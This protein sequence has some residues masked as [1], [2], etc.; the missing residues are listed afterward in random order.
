MDEFD[1][2]VA[3]GQANAEAIEL[4]RRHCRHARIELVHGNSTVGSSLN[5]S[6]GLMEVR[7]EH[8]PPPR[9]QSFQALELA[10]DFYQENCLGCEYRDG[11]GDLPNLA[12]V[13]AEF[14]TRRAAARAAAQ[15][16]ADQLALRREQRC[17]RRRQMR[18]GEGHV[19]RD[20][21]D[22]IDA[23]DRAGPRTAPLTAEEVRAERRVLDEV[24]GAPELFN[25]VLVDSLVEIAE[26]TADATALQALEALVRFG[27]CPPR[28]AL[29]AACTVL[30]RQRSVEAGQLLAFVEPELHP[31][32]LVNVLDQLINL[33]SVEEHVIRRLPSSPDG[34]IAASRV[35]LQAV[36]ARITDHLGSDDDRSREAGADAARELL[37]I[38]ATRIVTLGPPLVASVRGPDRV[39]AGNPHPAS[40][41]A[42]ALAEGWRG[43]PELTR[44]IVE[45]H[46]SRANQEVKDELSRVPR[47]LQRFREPW[48]AS[49]RATS[50]AISFAVRRAGGDWGDEAADRSADHLEGL[51][52]EIPDAVAI[53]IDE[54]LATILG[55]CSPVVHISA[56]L[57]E[58]A[59]PSTIVALER[60][61]RRI[62]RTTRRR[63]LAAAVGRTAAVSPVAVLTSV[64]ALFSAT[65]GDEGH[66]RAVRTTMLDVLEDAVAP[67][68]LRDILPITFT[69]LLDADQVVRSAGIDLWVAC[70]RVADSL[71]TELTELASPLLEDSHVVV[72]RKMLTQIPQLHLPAESAP[73]LILLVHAWLGTYAEAQSPEPRVVASAIRALRSLARQLDDESQI[74]AWHG[75]ALSYVD[76]CDPYDRERLLTSWWPVELRH[77]EA[78]VKMALATAASPELVDYYNQRREPLLQ[79]LMDRPQLLAGIALVDI[80]P[81]S[82]VHGTSHPWR[83]LEPVELLQAAGRWADALKIAG[84]VETRQPPGDEG[85]PG[86]RLAGTIAGAAKL[87][88]RLVEGP[89]AADALVTLTDAVLAAV[90]GVEASVANGVKEGQLRSTLDGA[91]ASATAARV[92]LAPAVPEPTMA[93]D[94]LEGAVALLQ[95]VS[96]VHAS[97]TQ[98]GWIARAW[99]IAVLLFRF[100][101]AVRAVLGEAPALLQAAQRQAQVLGSE[102]TEAGGTVIPD[103]LVE[104]LA[105]VENVAEPGAAQVAWQRLG[106]TPV[107]LSLVGT[108]LLPR[109][110]GFDHPSTEREEPPRA[111]CVA[112][113]RGVPVTDILVLRRGELY[114][115]GMTVR[116][117]AVPEW[118]ETCIVEPVTT[119][120]RDALALPR[121]EFS[122]GDGDIDEHGITLTGEE[123]LHCA[124]DQPILGPA[125]DCPLQVRLLG[126]GQDQMI[127]VVGLQRLRLRPFDPSCDALT[128][129]EQT[130]N[131]L[132]TMFG[133]LDSPDFDTE[134]VRAFCRLFAASVRASQVIMFEKTFGRGSKVTEGQFHNELERLLRAD[135]ELQG[136]LTRRDAVA[137]GFDD[138]LHDDVIAELKVSRGA[139]VTIDYCFHY[140]GQP[141]QYGVGR[142][143]Q[144]SVLVVLDHSRKEAPPGVI[145]NYVDWLKPRLHGLDDPRY[146]SLVGVIIVNTNLPVPNVWSRRR[147]EGERLAVPHEADP[148]PDSAPV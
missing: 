144:L 10:I 14:A 65:T 103:G 45:E 32:D 9:M 33:A 19:V 46:A 43:E 59:A 138:L 139:P 2:A 100:D 82:T 5:L 111:V 64:Q 16:V 71:P 90:A 143:S 134:D 21:G 147:I 66:D 63:R 148:P 80:E 123:P 92:L 118:A 61:G 35:D 38:D 130:D 105:E 27:R 127:E 39:Y 11:T 131:R 119:L 68:L 146:P 13:A 74:T 70:A 109:R 129:H 28:R 85:A 141:T 23:I 116:L 121:Y 52:R 137:G 47:Y 26:D 7:C 86:R 112:T 124:V 101:G 110:L 1:E 78:W 133:V 53:H 117:L 25:S 41:A 49:V 91:L 44:Q 15:E 58:T 73:R 84:D 12:T 40:A 75:V 48:N 136:R 115:L 120:G 54:L 6:M 55:L 99:Q 76:R 83:A 113:M 56:S 30:A 81:L 3:R 104:F 22:A 122:L 62:G 140:L 142:G 72:H 42:R 145:D 34:L 50:E 17:D 89:L 67:A 93:A 135:P 108:S 87:A 126:N 94:E 36:T 88:Q 107:P 18:A 29:D 132:L 98:R 20:L 4:T 125:L 114:H 79:V 51:A 24:Q 77:H 95:S 128:E 60:E 106:C 97:G 8:A 69:A 37:V 31:E 102:L 57:I 96:S